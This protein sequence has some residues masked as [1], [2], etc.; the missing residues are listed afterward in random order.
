VEL[1][2]TLLLL[3]VAFF[4]FIVQIFLTYRKQAAILHPTVEQLEESR[5][6]IEKHIQDTES[7]TW[8][9]QQSKEGLQRE[10]ELL[11]SR[12]GQL[13]ERLVASD[14]ILVPAGEFRMGEDEDGPPDEFPMHTVLLNAFLID[15]YPVTNAQYKLFVDITSYRI[16]P[17]WNRIGGNFPIDQADHPVVNVSWNDAKAYAKWVDKRLPTEAEWEK[18]ARGT[19]GQLYPWGDAF[20]KDNINCSN[21]QE[22]TTP[23]DAYPLGHSPYDVMDMC[24]N[25]CEWVED[26]FFDDYYKN[27]P[28]D[29][30]QGPPG[31]QYKTTRGGFFGE[32][33]AGVRCSS[34]HFAPPA[35]MQEHVGFRCAKT[36]VK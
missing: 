7:A 33:K 18:A 21:E 36:P 17:H 13:L 34:R 9:I 19:K 12:R 28:L 4:V 1:D 27:S 10:F 22:G 26:W 23:V 8:K 16:P 32:N 2:W 25:V 3:I 15:K 35:A 24:G 20:R 14:M 30:P 11:D 29:N 5:K 31:G 6:T